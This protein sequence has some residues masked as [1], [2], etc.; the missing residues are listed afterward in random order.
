MNAEIR[1]RSVVIAGHS[2]SISLEGPFWDALKAIAEEHGVSLNALVARID[3]ERGGN[4]SS[5]L[6]VFILETLQK[7]SAGQRAGPAGAPGA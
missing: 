6:R 7:K 4:L 2:T 3:G 5:A 1:K